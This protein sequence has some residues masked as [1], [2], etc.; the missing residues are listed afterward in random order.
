MKKALATLIGLAVGAEFGFGCEWLGH[1]REHRGRFV[2]RPMY[3]KELAVDLAGAVEFGLVG[4][5]IG[6]VCG[7]MLGRWDRAKEGT[8]ATQERLEQVWPPPR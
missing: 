8:P 6:F 5:L 1:V 3:S 2:S 4:S 7:A